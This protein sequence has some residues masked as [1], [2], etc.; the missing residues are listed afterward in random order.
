[1]NYEHEEVV[2]MLIKQNNFL[3]QFSAVNDMKEHIT[4]FAVKPIRGKVDVFQAFARVSSVLRDG[5]RTFNNKVNIGL[6]TCK[7]YDQYHVKR[8]NNCQGLGHYYRNCPTPDDPVC[9]T[10]GDNHSTRECESLVQRCA[11]CSKSG[12]TA[13]DSEHKANDQE[14]PSIRKV[15]EKMKRNYLNLRR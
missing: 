5:F 9:A 6:S 13:E 7:I 8:C 1:M 14:C 3:R 12:L 15:Q 10:C 2:D 11:N 4:V